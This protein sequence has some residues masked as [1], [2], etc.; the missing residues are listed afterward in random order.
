MSGSE[1]RVPTFSKMTSGPFTPPMVLYRIRGRM[2]IIRG[3]TVSGAIIGG[4][5]KEGIRCEAEGRDSDVAGC[6]ATQAVE[7][8][9][10][11]KDKW[12]CGWCRS[13]R[14][15]VGH[16]HLIRC[17]LLHF[18]HDRLRPARNVHRRSSGLDGIQRRPVVV[19]PRLQHGLHPAHA[20]VP[21]PLLEAL[22]HVR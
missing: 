2:L 6:E 15:I 21:V 13:M 20:R 5:A 22:I 14:H 19:V 11:A 17:K 16:G 8:D 1:L 7:L 3:S 4:R 9:G 18:A 12:R 10:A